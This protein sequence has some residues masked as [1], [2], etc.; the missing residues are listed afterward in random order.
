MGEKRNYTGSLA[1]IVLSKGSMGDISTNK[2][3]LFFAKFVLRAADM[4][5]YHQLE[6]HIS[7]PDVILI[8]RDKSGDYLSSLD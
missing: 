8:P 1:N 6:G 5:D 2:A 7:C 3:G 4:N